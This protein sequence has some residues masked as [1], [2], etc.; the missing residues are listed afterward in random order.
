MDLVIFNQKLLAITELRMNLVYITWNRP[1]LWAVRMYR[2]TN[3]HGGYHH[4]LG[5]VADSVDRAIEAAQL[6]S[7]ESRIESVNDKGPVDIVVDSPLKEK[8]GTT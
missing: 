3:V 1:R 8:N 6:S 5:V 2:K 4:T 7:P